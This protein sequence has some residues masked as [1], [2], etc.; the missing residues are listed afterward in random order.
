[1]A[2]EPNQDGGA[3]PALASGALP[4]GLSVGTPL[5]E[6]SDPVVALQQAKIEIDR[7]NGALRELGTPVLPIHDGVLVLPLIGH[8]DSLRGAHLMDDLLAAIESHQASIIILDITGVSVVDTAV[9]N[10][11]IQATRAA[12]LLGARCVLAGVTGAVSRTMVQLGIDLKQIASRRDLQDAITYAL[13]QQ[14]YAIVRTRDEIDWLT[15][16]TDSTP[17]PASKSG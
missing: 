4:S 12:G 10:M 15:E 16:F 7:L 11:L 1:M 6:I 5:D 9:A 2:Q 3:E 14:G 17:E 8:L 13:R